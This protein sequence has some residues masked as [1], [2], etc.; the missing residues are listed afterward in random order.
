[1]RF[2]TKS[3]FLFQSFGMDRLVSDRL[4]KQNVS[5]HALLSK[6]LNWSSGV[7]G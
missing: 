2:L 1:M 5:P 6:R 7:W 4:L 3:Q